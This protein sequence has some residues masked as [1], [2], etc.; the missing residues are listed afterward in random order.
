MAVKR[1]AQATYD[2]R[3]SRVM[4]QRQ[5]QEAKL[6]R[7]VFEDVRLAR[8]LNPDWKPGTFVVGGPMVNPLY[9][10]DGNR[11]D[12]RTDEEFLACLP[13]GVVWA[14]DQSRQPSWEWLHEILT[15]GQ[16]AVIVLMVE[17]V[18]DREIAEEL[19]ISRWAAHCHFV[20]ARRTIRRVMGV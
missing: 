10:R 13:P 18:S 5:R 17:G 8:W 2:A 20:C 4:L 3:T 16:F 14:P 1:F 12:G 11:R 7:K 19:R 9:L 15:P 6:L